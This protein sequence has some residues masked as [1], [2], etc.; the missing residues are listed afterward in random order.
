M[1]RKRN[2]KPVQVARLFKG[3]LPEDYAQKRALIQQYQQ[4]FESQES[5]AVFQMVKVTNVTDDYLNVT[6]PNAALSSY[7][8]L[9]GEQIRQSILE[10]FGVELTLKISTRPESFTQTEQKHNEDWLP[11]ISRSSCDQIVNAA[12]YVEGDELKDA[13]KSLSKTLAKNSH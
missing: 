13:L 11:E 3:L 7:L 9:H 6:L 4:F 10:S 1:T 12:E 2:K 5:D 8:R